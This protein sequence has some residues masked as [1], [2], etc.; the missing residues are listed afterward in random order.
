[1]KTIRT[2]LIGA[3]AI[4]MAVVGGVQSAGAATGGTA[5]G[6]KVCSGP[7]APGTYPGLVTKGLCIINK[8]PVNV[9][10]N[11]VVTP[12][13]GFNAVSTAVLTVSGDVLVGRGAIAGLGCS[14][15]VGCKALTPDNFHGN[16][17]ADHPL[18][19]IIQSGTINGNVSMTGGGGGRNC[20]P[21]PIL[22]SPNFS[23]IEDTN[24]FGNVSFTALR[25]CWLGIIRDQIHGNVT[26]LRNKFAD[27]DADEVVTNVIYGNAF[28]R[29][30]VPAPQKGDSG[31]SPNVVFGTKSGQCRHLP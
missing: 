22:K 18:D 6:P 15:E 16:I 7:L 14:P 25:T 30:N 8:G 5:S 9:Q 4:A 19:L 28:C 3:C 11:V 20:K 17:I 23:T 10:G 31:G 2:V 27:P 12:G 21:N 1:M 24:V 26:L 29:R 13:T